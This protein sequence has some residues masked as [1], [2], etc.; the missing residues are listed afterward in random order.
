MARHDDRE[1]G[2]GVSRAAVELTTERL[3]LRGWRPPDREPFA[4][5]NSDLEV[6]R[7]FPA[8]LDRGRSD[9]L[10]DVADAALRR[11]GWGLW[12]VERRTSGDFLGMVGLAPVGFEAAFTPAVEVG[13]R[14]A[15]SEWG[16]GYA[17]EAARAAVAFAFGELGLD[18]VVSFTATGNARSRAVMERLGMTY[19]P[20]DDFDHPNVSEGHP[21]RR[22]VLYR[23]LNPGTS[24][25]MTSGRPAT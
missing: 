6:M 8:P 13:W 5:L 17:T 12:A 23:L 25:P 18:E 2:A 16:H 11:H 3:R 15:R 14:L 20:A 10:A 24:A 9:A 21:L 19:D 4:A 1:A 22:H 7:H